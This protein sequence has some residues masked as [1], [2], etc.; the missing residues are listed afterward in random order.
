MGHV[1]P[2][3]GDF[4][5]DPDF[6]TLLIRRDDVRAA[7]QLR[8]LSGRQA[9][10]DLSL[11]LADREA[12]FPHLGRSTASAPGRGDG[13][14]QPRRNPCSFHWMSPSHMMAQIRRVSSQIRIPCLYSKIILVARQSRED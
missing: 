9:D 13:Q 2:I 1:H 4:V 7:E 6:A 11:H 3:G 5:V 12:I 10:F 14:T 8:N